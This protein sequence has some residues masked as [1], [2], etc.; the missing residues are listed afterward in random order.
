MFVIDSSTFNKEREKYEKLLT[1]LSLKY[2][3]DTE[4]ST[5]P[6]NFD[7]NLLIKSNNVSKISVVLSKALN[8]KLLADVTGSIRISNNDDQLLAQGQF[9]ILSSS[10]FTFYKTFQTEGNIKFTSDLADPTIN[11]TATYLADY[12]NRRDNEAEPVRT[13]VKIKVNDKVSTLLDNIAS[14][15][16]PIEMKIYMGQ[17]NIDYD[18]ASNQYNKLDAMYFI[19]FGAFSSDADNTDIANSAAMS[20][21]GS[22]L[23]TMLNANFGDLINNVNFNQTGKQTRFN[24]SGRVQKVRYTVGG[25]QEVFSDLSQA[26]AKVE[27]LFSPKFIIRAERKDPVISS[28]SGNN[29]K[30]SE[31]GVRYRFAF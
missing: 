22:T 24:I 2:G 20:V 15:E 13:A 17:K 16:N 4:V 12:I 10:M 19:L 1:A 7:L 5:I 25:T 21:L 18:V 9:D 30:I 27:Y 29:D 6:K 11:I 28:S 3:D 31:F 14:G 8:Q 26:N 23:T